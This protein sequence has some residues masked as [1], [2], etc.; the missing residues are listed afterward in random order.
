MIRDN[1]LPDTDETFRMLKSM[2]FSDKRLAELTGRSSEEVRHARMSLGVRPVYKR[3]DT[4]AA[5]FAAPTAYMYSTYE[6][7]FAGTVDDEARP[8]DRNKV[9]ILGGGPKPH[10][11]GHRVRLLLLPRCLR[12]RRCRLRDHHGQLPT[13][14]RSRPITTL[15]TGSIS[16]R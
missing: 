4:C 15:R 5:E 8:S 14:R 13:R 11:P 10:R 1:G 6:L 3:I 9:I 12:A 2:G 7:P 16:S